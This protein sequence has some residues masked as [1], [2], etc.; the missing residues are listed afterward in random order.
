ML[1]WTPGVLLAA[2]LFL[3]GI[4]SVPALTHPLE[5]SDPTQLPLTGGFV[6]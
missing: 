1:A 6:L 3:A 4:A 5:A 2:F